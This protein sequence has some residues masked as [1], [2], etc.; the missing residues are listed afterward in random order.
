MSQDTIPTNESVEQNLE[1]DSLVLP[2]SE[3]NTPFYRRNIGWWPLFVML[4]GLAVWFFG[5]YHIFSSVEGTLF[6]KKARFSF[7]D[8][9]VALNN[10]ALVDRDKA[11]AEHPLARESLEKEG[12][13]DSPE[14]KAKRVEEFKRRQAEEGLDAMPGGGMPGGQM[15][16]AS[17]G[18]PEAPAA[19]APH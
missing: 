10:V 11:L 17:Q 15:P 14:A 1:S 5:T 3:G 6:I 9:F 7:S 4:G 13:I 8:T 12:V 18:M 19:P 16:G 2:G